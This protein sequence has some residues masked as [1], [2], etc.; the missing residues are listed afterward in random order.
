MQKYSRRKA[1]TLI[2]VVITLMIIVLIASFGIS[3]YSKVQEESKVNIDVAAARQIGDA[4]ELALISNPKLDSNTIEDEVKTRI[5]MLKPVSKTYMD[6]KFNI[7]VVDGSPKVT[8]NK[9]ELYP[10]VEKI[11]GKEEVAKD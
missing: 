3:K 9:L 11:K 10:E 7:T 6:D 5:K 8:A 1:F 2:E 4:A